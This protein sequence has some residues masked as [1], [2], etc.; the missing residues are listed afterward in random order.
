MEITRRDWV[1]LGLFCVLLAGGV[2]IVALKA[3]SGLRRDTAE[4]PSPRTADRRVTPELAID[5]SPDRTAEPPILS[6]SLAPGEVPPDYQTIVERKLFTP[7]VSVRSTGQPGPANLEPMPVPPPAVGKQTAVKPAG[8]TTESKNEPK[9]GETPAGPPSTPTAPPKPPLAV[10]GL[11]RAGDGYRVIVENTE[12]NRSTVV[13][14]GQDAFGYRINEVSAE[15]GEVMI[16]KADSVDSG[17]VTL[18]LGENKKVETQ[19]AEQPA[20]STPSSSNGSSDGDRARS[21]S[22]G[23]SGGGWSRGPGGFDPSQLTPEQRA[24]F[25][26]YRRRRGDRGPGGGFGDRG[27]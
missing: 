5:E 10:T 8:K 3:N 22:S 4:L 17:D 1:I 18:K 27:R 14:V 12:L 7:L 2:G 23:Y 25:E 6:S 24:R 19:Q 21:S 15:T 20:A 16:A 9:P 11:V 13:R 26:E